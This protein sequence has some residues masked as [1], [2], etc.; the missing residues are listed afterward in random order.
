VPTVGANNNAPR[1]ELCTVT[2][3]NVVTD[4]SQSN[5][6]EKLQIS[7]YRGRCAIVIIPNTLVVQGNKFKRRSLAYENHIKKA[8]SELKNFS[9]WDSY[10][11]PKE[12]T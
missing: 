10:L 7:C 5:L 11:K 4:V 6:V 12:I 9:E 2:E 3:L 8:R 1:A